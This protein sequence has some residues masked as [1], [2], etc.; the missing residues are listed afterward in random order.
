M[1]G[2]ST[3]QG[4]GAWIC[5][6]RSLETSTQVILQIDAQVPSSENVANSA[7]SHP[8]LGPFLCT[9]PG[10]LEAL[11][12]N[13]SGQL[14]PAHYAPGPEMASLVGNLLYL[15]QRERMTCPGLLLLDSSTLHNRG[16]GLLEYGWGP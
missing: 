8:T 13:F 15:V 16:Q 14:W 1:L 4:I 9:C 7:P 11:P 3:T 6:F 12:Y 10:L 2:S 5:G